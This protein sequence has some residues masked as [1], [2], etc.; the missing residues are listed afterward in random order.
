MQL[1][2]MGLSGQLAFKA[3]TGHSLY[4]QVVLRGLFISSNFYTLSTHHLS[5]CLHQI[6][7]GLLFLAGE[8]ERRDVYGHLDMP[9][10]DHAEPN[11]N[12]STS[13]VFVIDPSGDCSISVGDEAD[14]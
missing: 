6:P 12:G 13:G 3:L 14:T 10:M 1:P 4:S 9:A 2:N 7:S 8:N 11:P 5:A